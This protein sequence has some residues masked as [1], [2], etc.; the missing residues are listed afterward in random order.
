MLAVIMTAI[1][2]MTIFVMAMM[3]LAVLLMITHRFTT[4]LRG[5][6]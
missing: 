3:T 5:I 4:F 6:S 1:A 2:I